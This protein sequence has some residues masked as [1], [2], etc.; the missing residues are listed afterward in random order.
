MKAA[1]VFIVDDSAYARR[2][3]SD[4]LSADPRFEVIGTA[5]DPFAAAR[6]L[7]KIRPDVILLDLELPR[8]HGLDFLERLMA[9]HPLPVVV[10][11]DEI[12]QRR[13]ARRRG[14][15]AFVAKPDGSPG[16][17][18]SLLDTIARAGRS[19]VRLRQRA[20]A[21][22]EAE[23]L[24]RADAVLGFSAANVFRNACDPV[25][26]LGASTGGTEALETV[27]R[28]FSATSPATV[29]VQHMPGQFTGAFATRLDQICGAQ[30]VEA[31]D[32]MRLRR[33]LVVLARG[34]AHLIVRRARSHH[35]VELRD[36]P[37]VSRHRPSVDVLFRS[38]ALAF[39]PSSVAA[40]LTGMGSDGA[41][42]LRE[43]RDVGAHT[44][45]QDAS[46]CV[47]FGMPKE[48]I[49]L[50]AARATLPLDRIG[51]ALLAEAVRR[52]AGAAVA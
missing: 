1:R 13:E 22:M 39:G 38:V 47:V 4:A 27:L 49:A 15:V 12:E 7:S 31:T 21:P 10:C 8:M 44:I 18:A 50:G 33:G 37:A 30:V 46:T 5:V 14:A 25:V 43:L 24:M 51:P 20:P 40:L 2:V 42:G 28:P 23:P 6:K 11:T 9:Q 48:A 32:G 29:I 36:G 26:A 52:A 34:D 17:M 16:A 41:R 45:A 3:F 19:A 35:F